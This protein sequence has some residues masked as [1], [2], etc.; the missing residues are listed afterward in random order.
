MDNVQ[1]I[2]YQFRKTRLQQLGIRTIADLRQ[3]QGDLLRNHATAHTSLRVKTDGMDI[4][5]CPIH[6]LW[7][8]YLNRIEQMPAIG[9][10]REYK[11]QQL[12]EERL[13]RLLIS[14]QGYMKRIAALQCLRL[15]KDHMD[16][17]QVTDFVSE[18]L[19]GITDPLSWR[20][21]VQKRIRE[22]RLSND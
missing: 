12:T 16:I 20:L 6:P 9:I 22:M 15:G 19:L 1:R 11:T 2:E 21:D 10:V 3:R 13:L 8:D 17:E 5:D 4:K 18:R 7:Q 14:V